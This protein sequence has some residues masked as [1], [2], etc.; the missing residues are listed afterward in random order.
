[1]PFLCLIRK[2]TL[3]V[4][5]PPLSQAGH[6]GAI[7]TIRPN[8]GRL[9]TSSQ[10]ATTHSDQSSPPSRLVP[11]NLIPI[12]P[13]HLPAASTSIPRCGGCPSQL[14]ILPLPRPCRQSL[15]IP[16]LNLYLARASPLVTGGPSGWPR[17]PGH[18]HLGVGHPLSRLQSPFTASCTVTDPLRLCCCSIC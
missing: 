13:C 11:A 9:R 6:G 1:M 8:F 15:L 2:C 16:V 4:S 7:P 10:A 18:G 3:G 5:Q 17:V 12:T 14:L